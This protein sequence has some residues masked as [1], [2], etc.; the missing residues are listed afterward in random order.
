MK[1]T[2]NS[3]PFFLKKNTSHQYL[4]EITDF[5][6][7]L[8]YLKDHE[9]SKGSDQTVLFQLHWGETVKYSKVRNLILLSN[10]QFQVKSKL[11]LRS[12]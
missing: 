8:S 6:F 3:N 10:K 11:H 1:S 2:N 7:I 5:L 9:D 4:F 12:G